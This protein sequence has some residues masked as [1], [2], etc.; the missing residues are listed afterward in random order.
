M[1]YTGY[2]DRPQEERQVR[3]Q[4]GCREGH[5]EIAFAAT[6]TNLQ[7]VFGNA[8]GNYAVDPCDCDFDK[9]HGKVSQHHSFV[10]LSQ[11][12]SRPYHHRKWFSSFAF[13]VRIRKLEY[14]RNLYK[15]KLINSY[16]IFNDFRR[17]RIYIVEIKKNLFLRNTWI[18]YEEKSSLEW[19][20][21][22]R[23]TSENWIIFS[24]RFIHI[25]ESRER[26]CVKKMYKR[27][28]FHFSTKWD[29]DR[30]SRRSL[31][32]AV[33]FGFRWKRLCGHNWVV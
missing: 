22:L 3:F 25:V 13:A 6:G 20:Y 1:R 15:N 30:V 21:S 16:E 28:E 11:F 24:H 33:L 26:Y 4:N 32:A 5:T 8:S 17:N 7:L 2:R 29:F 10:R 18:K 31:G 14:Y 19:L 23:G 12:S 9:E 27:I